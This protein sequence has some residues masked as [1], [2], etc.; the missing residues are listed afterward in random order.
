MLGRCLVHQ[1]AGTETEFPESADA[2]L[3]GYCSLYSPPTS[4]LLPF[5]ST[6][7]FRSTVRSTSILQYVLLPFYSHSTAHFARSTI[8]ILADT[9]FQTS[10]RI[11]A[12]ITANI[13]WLVKD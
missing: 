1:R 4:I 12:R 5:Y 8:P 10:A 9:V 2:T 13:H 6:F 11:T 3:L 7:Y